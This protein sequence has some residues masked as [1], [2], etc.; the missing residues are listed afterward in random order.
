MYF[1]NPDGWE[2]RRKKYSPPVRLYW[3]WSEKKM[4]KCCDLEVCDSKNIEKYIDTI[5]NKPTF[6]LL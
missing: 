5:Y 1:H 6:Y 4:V 2:F 3:K